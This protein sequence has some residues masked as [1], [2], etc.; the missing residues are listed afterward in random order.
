MEINVVWA[1]CFWYMVV[2]GRKMQEAGEINWEMVY[3]LMFDIGVFF[4]L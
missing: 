2:T 1:L 4:Y 3:V